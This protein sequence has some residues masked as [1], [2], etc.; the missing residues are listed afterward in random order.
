MKGALN[1]TGD[2]AADADKASAAPSPPGKRKPRRVNVGAFGEAALCAFSLA[3]L[4][5]TGWHGTC[6]QNNRAGRRARAGVYLI[7]PRKLSVSPRV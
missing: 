1:A 5:V 2:Q 6:N 7:L 3:S 4:V